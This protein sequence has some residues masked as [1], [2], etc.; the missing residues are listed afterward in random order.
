MTVGDDRHVVGHQAA[1]VR[2]A[3]AIRGKVRGKRD[4]C[5]RC[6]AAR[7][8]ARRV[9]VAREGGDRYVRARRCEAARQ[10]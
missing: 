7:R 10:E 4:L 8:A 9:W 3:S 2:A 5:R 1:A 6:E